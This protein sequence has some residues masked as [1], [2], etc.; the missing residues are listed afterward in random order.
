[1]GLSNNGKPKISIIGAGSAGFSL[2]MIR[3]ICLTRN[4]EGSTVSFMDV[5]PERL[6]AAYV[7]C[8]RYAHELGVTLTLEKTLDRRES[9][10]G[11]DFVINTALTTGH[12]HMKEGWEISLRRGYNW[13]ASFHV[14]Y[15]E[16]F[17][18][19]YYQFKFFEAVTEDMLEICPDAWHLLVANPVLAGVTHITR[20]YPQAK[21]VGLCHGFS[22]VY[23]LAKT[24]GLDKEGLTFEIPG[25]NHFVWLTHCYYQGQDVFPLIDRWIDEELP[26]Y[27]AEGREAP[28][29]SRKRCD[30][31][32]RLGAFPIGDTASITGAS[33]P[34]WY[35]SD[36]EKEKTWEPD[37]GGWWYRYN[38]RCGEQ[39][40]ES[41]EVAKDASRKLT[42][43]MKPEPSGE[44]M[45][46][47]IE[48][49]TCD[50]P[51]VIIGNIQNQGAL[52]P[53]IPEDFEVEVPLLVSK[54]GIEG[55]RTCGLP[56]AIVAHALRDRVAPVNL[57]L[58]AYNTG[59]RE[60]LLQMVMMDPWNRSEEQANGLID[61]VFALPYHTEVCRHYR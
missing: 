37:P 43:Y 7:I 12:P 50:I 29:M 30:L 20:K 32:R 26:K 39:T 3:D 5:D 53:G 15:D 49:I 44:V 13:P 48:S 45:V 17:Y 19:N 18:V 10:R 35:H 21:I 51:R 28:G 6:D 47:I 54:R 14:M 4:L 56:Q 16:P 61:E 41:I 40:R 27:V 2:Q 38:A 1:M 36:A 52:V 8:Q 23:S 42:E 60:L 9:L 25:V 33:W 58:E 46:P 34:L 31:F 11:A 22:G 59:S 24:L 57:E 55:V